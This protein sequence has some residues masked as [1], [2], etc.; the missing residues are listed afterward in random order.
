MAGIQANG[1]GSG[2]DINGL[3]SQLVA[4]ERAPLQ[5]RIVR[6]ETAATTKLSALGSLKGAMGAFKSA[7]EAL[8]SAE[9]MEARKA[10]SGDADIFSVTA[11]SKA[12]AGRYEV[13]VVRLAQA[14]QLASEPFEAGSSAQVG[15]GTL[16]ITVGEESFDV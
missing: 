3:V 13:E 14:H 5:Q 8:K 11:T 4:A 16:T 12:V 6:Q 2:L 15:H 10:T 9:A 1:V 7:L